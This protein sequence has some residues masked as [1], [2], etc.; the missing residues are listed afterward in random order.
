M[1]KSASSRS[2]YRYVGCPARDGYVLPT[3]SFPKADC[4]SRH[5]QPRVEVGY[6][7]RRIAFR[8]ADYLD[9]AA[10]RSRDIG[11]C[12]RVAAINDRP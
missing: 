5:K 3:F 8:L 7:S 10:W 9:D 4:A 1:V 11:V 6:R 12:N 2:M